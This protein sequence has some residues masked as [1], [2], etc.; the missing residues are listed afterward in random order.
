MV[1]EGEA[2]VEEGIEDSLGIRH[3]DGPQLG[4]LENIGEVPPL[5]GSPA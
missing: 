3:G 1:V 4:L 5:G 2:D